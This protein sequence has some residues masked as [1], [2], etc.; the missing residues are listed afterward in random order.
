[1]WLVPLDGPARLLR[2]RRR[3]HHAGAARQAARGPRAGRAPRRRSATCCSL[4][5]DRT[6]RRFDGDALPHVPLAPSCGAASASS[7]APGESRAGRRRACSA[8]T[9]AVERVDADRRVARRSPRRRARRVFAGTV[10]DDGPLELRGDR[11]RRR[12]RCSRGIVRHGRRG[13]G[14]EGADAAAGRPGVAG[15]FVPAVLAIAVVDARGQRASC[16]ATGPTALLRA[17]RGAG[18]RLPLRAR[19]SRRRRR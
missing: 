3:D 13:A 5:A 18:H 6:V 7:C 15:V 8:G 12:R 9:S 16:S 1:M 10:N 4:A 14:V 2:G 19:A 11:G 17:D